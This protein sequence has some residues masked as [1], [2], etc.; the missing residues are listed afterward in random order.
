[1]GTPAPGH[2]CTS[3]PSPSCNHASGVH[4]ASKCPVLADLLWRGAGL[5]VAWAPTQRQR[6]APP[7]SE[8]VGGEQ[9]LCKCCRGLSCTPP[10]IGRVQHKICSG[11]GQGQGLMWC[12]TLAALGCP[13][14][15]EQVGRCYTELRGGRCEPPSPVGTAAPGC[16][17]PRAVAPRTTKQY[18]C[19]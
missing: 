4:G 3:A 19:D 7:P 15:L 12:G 5:S 2:L 13:P 6:S 17:V 9:G 1:M 16:F 10:E 8:Q 18:L 11:G 14:P